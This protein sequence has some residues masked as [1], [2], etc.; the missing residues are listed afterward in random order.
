MTLETPTIEIDSP[1]IVAELTRCPNPNAILSAYRVGLIS[2]ETVFA[3]LPDNRPSRIERII[4]TW[5]DVILG[6]LASIKNF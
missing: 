4:D 3:L 5:R 6:P 1:W 2:R